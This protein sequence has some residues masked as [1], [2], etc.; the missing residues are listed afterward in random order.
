MLLAGVVIAM[1]IIP[2]GNPSELFQDTET[3]TGPED[4]PNKP[5]GEAKGINPG[6]V[7]W[8]WNPQAT[9]EKFEHNSLENY[10]WFVSPQNN[11]PEVIAKMFRDGVLKLTGEKN[12]AKSWDA[13]FKFFNEK[14]LN[15]KNGY[16]K[17]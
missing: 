8:V 14:K 2:G 3:R 4:G 13:M 15:K 11:N 7:V 16:N 17:G 9:N 6:R 10:D 5:I 1:A 12:L